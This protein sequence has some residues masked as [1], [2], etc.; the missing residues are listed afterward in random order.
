MQRHAPIPRVR[1][2]RGRYSSGR[3]RHCYVCHSVFLEVATCTC[4]GSR[5]LLCQDCGSCLANMDES[6]DRSFRP[7]PREDGTNEPPAQPAR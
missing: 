1:T 4:H 7:P 3:A 6:E 5:F 2:V